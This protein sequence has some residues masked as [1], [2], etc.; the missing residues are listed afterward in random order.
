MRKKE[1]EITDRKEIEG[2][3][4]GAEI[5]RIALVD[6]DV[7][8]I[9]PV[10]FGYKDGRI[11]FHS[12][13]EGRKIDIIRRNNRV[14]F[15]V[16]VDYRL[17]LGGAPCDWGMRYRSVIGTGRAHI[18]EDDIERKEGLQVL[19]QHYCPEVEDVPTA[20][21]KKA[22]I[23]RIDIDEMTGKRSDELIEDRYMVP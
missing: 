3:L 13:L 23:I 7:P 22:L 12:A 4:H 21:G 10:N 18:V 2:I 15:E 1:K 14:C 20:R 8:Y 19:V 9:V 6:G 5:C 16:D 11:Y 17:L